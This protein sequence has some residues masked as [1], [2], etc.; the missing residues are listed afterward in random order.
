MHVDFLHTDTA[1]FNCQV[2]P[3]P[4]SSSTPYPYD[5][6]LVTN[7]MLSLRIQLNFAAKIIQWDEL[8][9]PMKEGIMLTNY[10]AICFAH[11]QAPDQ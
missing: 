9:I 10:K 11:T 6:I 8:V 1:T 2:D 5:I 3:T 4:A 7:F